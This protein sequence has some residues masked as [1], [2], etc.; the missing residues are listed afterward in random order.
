[1]N[2]QLINLPHH[3]GVAGTG[4]QAV[5]AGNLIFVGGQMSLDAAGRVVGSDIKTQ[6]RNAFEALQRVLVA[7]GA[8][9]ADV[10]KHNV[11]FQCPGDAVAVAK[12]LD[13]LDEVRLDYFTDP[14]PTTTE[15]RVG[16]DREGALIQVDAWAVVGG[17]KERLM[18]DGHWSW[19]KQLLAWLEGRGHGV[20]R[21][22]EVARSTGKRPG[23][24]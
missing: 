7:A 3:H 1:M 18:P 16:L 2:K 8:T 10:V 12:F 20:R 9:M 14:G 23:C 19:S 5:R 22:P 15:T 24:G 11:Y 6:A 4:T 13:E 17:H 21:G